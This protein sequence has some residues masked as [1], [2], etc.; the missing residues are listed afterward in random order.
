MP[1]A[2]TT[3]FDVM[4][5]ACRGVASGARP[6]RDLSGMFGRD[7]ELVRLRV[8]LSRELAKFFLGEQVEGIA[9][10][11]P[12]AGSKRAEIVGGHGLPPHTGFHVNRLTSHMLFVVAGAKGWALFVAI[13]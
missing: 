1:P 12:A 11:C 9:A 3:S 8:E 5:V 4:R 10:G 6:P 13:K 2:R 7:V